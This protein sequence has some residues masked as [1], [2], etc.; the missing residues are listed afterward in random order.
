[1][2]ASH[3]S[4]E[5]TK[6]GSSGRLVDF[7][8]IG[9]VIPVF[10]I[11]LPNT[12]VE[13]GPRNLAQFAIPA[14]VSIFL[15]VSSYSDR[16]DWSRFRLNYVATISYALYLIHY[17]VLKYAQHLQP[18]YFESIPVW[19]IALPVTILLATA[20]HHFYEKPML[21]AK[22]KTVFMHVVIL[23]IVLLIVAI[24]WKPI[25]RT[26][27]GRL[28]S[29]LEAVETSKKP[30]R[31]RSA[32]IEANK[33][34]FNTY[35]PPATLVKDGFKNQFGHYVWPNNTGQLRVVVVG[36]SYAV[37]QQVIVR[38]FLPPSMT[39]SLDVYA[40]ASYSIVFHRHEKLTKLF[41]EEMEQRKKPN[42]VFILMRYEV[43]LW[44]DSAVP[45]RPGNDVALN[46]WLQAVNRLSKFADHIFISSHHP[47]EVSKYFGQ[48]R[49]VHDVIAALENGQDLTR[50]NFPYNAEKFAADPVRVRI[51]LL[52]QQC[53]KC[54]LVDIES[55]FINKEKNWVQT[56]D[57]VTNIVYYDAW[58]H[59]TD[60]ALKL[61]EPNFEKAIRAALPEYFP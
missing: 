17:P 33:K 57:R 58:N 24:Q 50:L 37:Q 2:L 49:L 43:Y 3:F 8:T 59:Y 12:I 55:P 4:E 16:I 45:L 35:W 10:A 18:R 44:P 21:H 30:D 53:K 28:E 31:A 42:I 61:I 22:K 52:L 25:F 20:C 1:M 39:A 41:W 23:F 38:K 27:R 5:E 15:M 40:A 11:F 32:A 48:R 46:Y 34:W 51:N 54:H 14:I 60:D 9:L 29:I 6:Y 26:D 19:T 36:N 47:F 7:A 13:L 56:Y